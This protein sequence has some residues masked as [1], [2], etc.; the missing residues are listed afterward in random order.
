MNQGCKSLQ[1]HLVNCKF[2]PAMEAKSAAAKSACIAAIILAE[3]SDLSMQVVR[4]DASRIGE[5][6]EKKL[7]GRYSALARLRNANPESFY[8]W[9]VIQD[10]LG[11]GE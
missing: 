6:K 5:L 1:N 7:E 10:V 3:K 8:Y 4:F 11:T 9:T 2:N